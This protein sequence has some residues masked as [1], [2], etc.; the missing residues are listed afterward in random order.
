MPHE[1]S[2]QLSRKKEPP[3]RSYPH[4]PKSKSS[5]FLSKAGRFQ[6]ECS[7]NPGPGAY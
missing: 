2:V 3:R 1:A 7:D 6:F 4:Q 5:Q